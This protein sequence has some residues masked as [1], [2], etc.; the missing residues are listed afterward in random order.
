[1]TGVQTCAL[2]IS[3]NSFLSSTGKPRIISASVSARGCSLVGQ[4]LHNLSYPIVNLLTA[5]PSILLRPFICVDTIQMVVRRRIGACCDEN[6]DT[7]LLAKSVAAN[8]KIERL[9]IAPKKEGCL[10]TDDETLH[11]MSNQQHMSKRND[12]GAGLSLLS[13]NWR[14][15]KVCRQMRQGEEHGRPLKRYL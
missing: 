9:V 13:S 14:V 12:G 1:M 8:S 5:T 11:A 3:I 7:L 10:Y 15:S 6:E 4:D 2:P